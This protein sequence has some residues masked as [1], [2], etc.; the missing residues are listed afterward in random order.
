MPGAIILNSSATCPENY[1]PLHCL[2]SNGSALLLWLWK[3][4]AKVVE[5][6]GSERSGNANLH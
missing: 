1:M 3:G 4:F 5:I 2:V 6:G